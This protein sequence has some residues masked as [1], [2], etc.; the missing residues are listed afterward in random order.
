MADPKFTTSML[1]ESHRL[2]PPQH[3][4]AYSAIHTNAASNYIGLERCPTGH[5]E[6]SKTSIIHA[7]IRGE[8]GIYGLLLF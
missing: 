5:M 4:G 2:P 1:R 8:H 7:L 3:F 6:S